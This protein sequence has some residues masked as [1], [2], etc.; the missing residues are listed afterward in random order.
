MPQIETTVYVDVELD[1]FNDEEL[2]TEIERR[3]YAVFE[4]ADAGA[5]T[6]AVEALQRKDKAE[7]FILLERAIPALKGLLV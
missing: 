2:V 7:A 1:D 3:G 4:E 6:A 5:F